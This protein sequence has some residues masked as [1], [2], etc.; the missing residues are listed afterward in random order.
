MYFYLSY[1]R[2]YFHF[3]SFNIMYIQFAHMEKRNKMG[4]L[5]DKKEMYT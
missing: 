3:I 5:S 1:F 2:Q 4:I